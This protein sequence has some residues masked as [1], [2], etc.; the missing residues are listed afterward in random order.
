MPLDRSIGERTVRDGF[1]GYPYM[2]SKRTLGGALIAAPMLLLASVAQGATLTDSAIFS[3]NGQGNNWNGWIWNTQGLPAD[4]QNRFNMYYSSSSDPS[5]PVFI[6]GGNDAGA[7]I[8]IDLAAGV[9]DFYVYGESSTTNIDPAQHF[10]LNLYFNGNQSAPDISGLYGADCPTVCAA[11]H[12]NGLD[13]FGVSGLDSPDAQ[14][15]G[16][17]TFIDGDLSISLT[18]FEWAIGDDVDEVGPYSTNGSGTPDFFGHFQLTVS[19]VP[20]P[21][22]F[23]LMGAGLALIGALRRR[24]A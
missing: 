14:E 6:N 11:S 20:L 13:L 15:A 23:P 1:L 21:A 22:G 12:W 24:K 9:Y 18:L 8:S 5:A 10:V 19:E 4:T 3:S 2:F 7:G 17:L 16:T